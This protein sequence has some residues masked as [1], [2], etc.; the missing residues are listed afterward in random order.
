LPQP[1]SVETAERQL[2]GI[3][4]SNFNVTVVPIA[5]N[6]ALIDGADLRINPQTKLA[7]YYATSRPHALSDRQPTAKQHLH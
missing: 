1:S 4:G 5:R 3:P 6:A 2:A 7:L